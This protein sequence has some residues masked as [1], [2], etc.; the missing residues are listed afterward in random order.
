V[1]GRRGGRDPRVPGDLFPTPVGQVAAA[2]AV[3]RPAVGP[4]AHPPSYPVGTSCSLP[5]GK[6]A[7]A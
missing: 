4:G 3:A 2:T 7:G 6:A 5:G 1:Y